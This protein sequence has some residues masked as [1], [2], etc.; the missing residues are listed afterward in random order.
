[1]DISQVGVRRGGDHRTPRWICSLD[2]CTGRLWNPPQSFGRLRMKSCSRRG[3]E[4]VRYNPFQP[5][6]YNRFLRYT[7]GIPHSGTCLLCPPGYSGNTPGCLCQSRK[8][9]TLRRA[10]PPFSRDVR[11][12]AFSVV[13][14]ARSWTVNPRTS[15][16]VFMPCLARFA[17]VMLDLKL[18]LVLGSVFS[19]ALV[20]ASSTPKDP[21]NPCGVRGTWNPTSQTCSCKPGWDPK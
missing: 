7:P 11:P 18:S 4:V 6:G 3:R 21:S 16:L 19:A 1:V 15:C 5:F 2:S 12:I 17:Q 13:L 10:S 9:Q 8:Q 20:A 14:P